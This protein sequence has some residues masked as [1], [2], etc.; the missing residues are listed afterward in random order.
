MRRKFVSS[1]SFGRKISWRI[2]SFL[3]FCSEVYVPSAEISLVII[4]ISSEQ[5]ELIP[6]YSRS[7]NACGWYR[8]WVIR[9]LPPANNWQISND[10]F[11][12]FDWNPGRIAVSKP[13]FRLERLSTSGEL[14]INRSYHR[15]N[16][17]GNYFKI[18]SWL[19]SNVIKSTKDFQNWY[20][21]T[22]IENDSLPY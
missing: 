22:A 7:S 21:C 11:M 8:M 9:K 15:F 10:K 14:K 2:W 3:W 5:A 16:T 6:L 12:K 17:S 20:K 4:G 18:P 13:I 19:K 1:F